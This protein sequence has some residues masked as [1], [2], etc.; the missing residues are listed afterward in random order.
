MLNDDD[1]EIRND[2]ASVTSKLLHAQGFNP[3]KVNAVPIIAVQQLAKFLTKCFNESSD[4]CREALRRLVGVNSSSRLFAKPLAD[5]LVEESKEDTALFSQEKQNLFKDDV[6]DVALWSNVLKAL[7]PSTAPK[8]LVMELSA[9]VLGGLSALSE[10]ARKEIDGPLGWTSKA[11][12]FVLGMRVISAADVLV[13][14]NCGDASLIKLA[15]RKF[16]DV[17][18]A[19]EMNALWLEKIEHVLE[20]SVFQSI[21]QVRSSIYTL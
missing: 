17:G 5:I 4:L 2:A 12:V 18:T 15:L 16:A 21:G 1:D 7:P 13:N 19:S 11:E 6:M 10:T 20:K 9:W 3:T 8:T 14:W